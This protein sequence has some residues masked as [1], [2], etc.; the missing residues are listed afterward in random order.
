MPLYR[1]YFL[2]RDDHIRE[3]AEI[4]ADAPGMAV[5]RALELLRANPQYY[6]IEIWQGAQRVYPETATRHVAMI[7]PR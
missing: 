3:R 2:D 6:S 5:D 4:E 7:H 1:C